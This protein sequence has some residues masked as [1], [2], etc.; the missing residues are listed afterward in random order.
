MKNRTGFPF[1]SFAF[2]GLITGIL[3]FF[4][5][6]YFAGNWYA[7][8]HSYS[9]AMLFGIVSFVLFCFTLLL[10]TRVRFLDRLFGHDTVL[11]L[12]GYF[13]ATALLAGLVHFIL[14]TGYLDSLTV[15]NVPGI[16]A[17]TIGIII[18]VMTLVYMSAGLLGGFPPFVKLRSHMAKRYPFDYSRAKFFHNVFSFVVALLIFHVM[19][20]SSTQE[21][22]VRTACIGGLGSVALLRYLYHKL[23]RP[24]V[25]KAKKYHLLSVEKP[26]SNIVRLTFSSQNGKKTNFLPGQFAYV[27][28]LSPECSGEE[29]PFSFSSSPK[30]P[31]LQMT[32]KTIGDYTSRLSQIK[33]GTPVILDG[34]Y[35][36]FTPAHDD[37]NKVFIAGGIGITPLLSVLSFWQM[38]SNVPKTTLFWS[39]GHEED[40]VDVQLLEQMAKECPWFTFAPILTKEQLSRYKHGR[41]SIEYMTETLGVEKLVTSDFYLCGPPPMIRGLVRSLRWQG[42][43]KQRI[44]HELFAF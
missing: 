5:N 18:G 39:V 6:L 12:H 32:I 35:G 41:L 26:A 10:S 24:I 31:N 33:P 29:H 21:S 4:V 23:L 14:K 3:L 17:L 42:V 19:L 25:N 22:L 16:G 30:S 11:R 36:K 37:R 20:A 9:L 44:H 43:P 8:G 40:L 13:A 38:M 27:R 2:T 34:P 1:G 7:I 15:Q 28:I